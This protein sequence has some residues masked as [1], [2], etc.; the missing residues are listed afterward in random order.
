VASD[1]TSFICCANSS[2]FAFA[3]P[4]ARTGIVSFVFESSA[5][6]FTVCWNDTKYAQPARIR[7]G[8]AY[9]AV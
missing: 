7:P 3:P 4:M 8:R 1:A 9:A 2:P 6:S 5:K